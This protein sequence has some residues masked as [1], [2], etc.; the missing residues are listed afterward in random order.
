MSLPQTRSIFL[1][2]DD[3]DD[4]LFFKEALDELRVDIKLTI[5]NDGEQ[6]MRLLSK[7]VGEPPPLLFLDLNMPRKNG[8]QCLTE[9]KQ[10]ERLKQLTV[11]IFSTSY[12]QDVAD[13]L[14]KN[15]AHYF[16]LK[17]ATFKD[18]KKVIHRVIKIMEQ[19]LSVPAAG[20]AGIFV[21][22]N[23]ENFVIL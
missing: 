17:P 12:Q 22:P 19:T 2:D 16:I 20:R 1:A 13:L 18:L 5:V 9:I 3:D 7:I 10:D 21:Q 4:C 14:Y 8:F 11:V 6:L 23:R 15:G